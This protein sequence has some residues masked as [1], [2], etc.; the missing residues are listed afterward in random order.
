MTRLQVLYL[1][2]LH[3]LTE[4]SAQALAALIWGAN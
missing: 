1:R 2:R 4:S 3:G